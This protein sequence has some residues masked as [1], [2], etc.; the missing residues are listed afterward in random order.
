MLV[1]E[2]RIA[3]MQKFILVEDDVVGMNSQATKLQAVRY[4]CCQGFVPSS[5]ASQTVVA[6]KH[7]LLSQLC[8][9]HT[10][11]GARFELDRV[12][13]VRSCW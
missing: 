2:H 7:C 6:L 13:S 1:H 9:M 11:Q 4:N 5:S 10:S 8:H 3:N 12:V